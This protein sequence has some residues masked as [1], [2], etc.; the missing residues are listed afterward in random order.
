MLNTEIYIYWPPHFISV[1]IDLGVFNRV[2]ASFGKLSWPWTLKTVKSSLIEVL[3]Q[4][5]HTA[6]IA[7]S[8]F[9][10]VAILLATSKSSSE[11]ED[12]DTSKSS[13]ESE[14]DCS[15]SICK[16]F[17]PNELFDKILELQCVPIHFLHFNFLPMPVL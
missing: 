3:V 16:Q 2:L 7:K 15:L 14:D 10:V 17:S 5:F 6:H 8:S 1:I 4:L 12:D 13:S 11:S 9:I